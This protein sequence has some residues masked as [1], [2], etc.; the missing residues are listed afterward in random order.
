MNNDKNIPQKQNI[1]FLGQKIKSFYTL[2]TLT[3]LWF[4]V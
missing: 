1:I 4:G 2:Q 3:F